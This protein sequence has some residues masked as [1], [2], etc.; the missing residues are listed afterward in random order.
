MQARAVMLQLRMRQ[1]S[2]VVDGSCRVFELRVVAQS[3]DSSGQAIAVQVLLSSSA[4]HQRIG[5]CHQRV[6][7]AWGGLAVCPAGRI[8]RL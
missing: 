2:G 5:G 6:H 7:L 1:C 4:A 8:D 3:P